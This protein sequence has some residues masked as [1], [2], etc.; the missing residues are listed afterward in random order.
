MGYVVFHMEKARDSDSAM[1]AH[2]ERMSHP[3]NAD[4]SR[5]HLNRTLIE[6]PEGVKDRTAAIQH[7]LDHAGLKRKIGSNQVRAIRINLSGS[8]EDMARIEANGQLEAWCA[9]SLQYLFDTFGRENIVAAHLHMDEKTPHIHATLVPIVR[10]ARTRRKKEEQVKR[11]YRK[12]SADTPRLCADD[13]MTR[14]KLKSYQDG[15]AKAM[16]R[17]GLQRGIDGSEARHIS[18]R[19]YYR[20][21]KKQSHELQEDIDR[22]Q[23]DKA[24]AGEALR[25]TQREVRVERLKDSA[26]A[27]AT[28]ITD[29]IGSLF[30]GGKV[31]A[32]EKENEALKKQIEALESQAAQREQHI[33]QME[34]VH[35]AERNRL[36]D[37]IEKVKRYFPQVEKLLPLV[38]F[39]RKTMHFSEELCRKL[40]GLKPLKV[41]GMLY[42]DKFDHK[43]PAENTSVAFGHEKDTDEHFTLL[44]DG[45]DFVR[46]FRQRMGRLHEDTDLTRKQ[47][48]G[49]R[50]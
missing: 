26:A 8:P 36:L 17:Y 27:A 30:G 22:L 45:V 13:I 32:L 23:A 35:R 9:D 15:Y 46:W 33:R 25:Q 1:T 14:G 28:Q 21:L 40:C 18:T 5:T 24:V 38:D 19:Q 12:K 4:E 44:L 43:F 29:S 42:S 6:Y 48:R 34:E 3:K 50:R 11:H 20:D 39:C 47:D 2:I 31:K 7:R 16:I 49:V 37:Y 10:E 41:S